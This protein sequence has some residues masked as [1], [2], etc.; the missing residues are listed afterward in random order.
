[1]GWPGASIASATPRVQLGAV[2]D[3]RRAFP[4]EDPHRV[5][6]REQID[7][8][9]EN[10]SKEVWSDIF[11]RGTLRNGWET[12]EGVGPL[13]SVF[14]GSVKVEGMFEQSGQVRVYQIEKASLFVALEAD[15]FI[16]SD[17]VVTA[18]LFIARER[19]AGREYE[20]Q[21]GV[22][23][24]R[25]RDGLLQ[26]EII[27]RGVP[28][29]PIDV[30]WVDDFQ[31]DRWVRLRI[32]RVG[33]SSDPRVTISVNGTPVAERVEMPDLGQSQN[34]I[35]VGL[36]VEGDTARTAR[37]LLDNVEIVRKARR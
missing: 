4:E 22:S 37:V 7:R 35:K 20:I 18:G 6:A 8:I 34:D 29:E 24:Q 23:V 16:S 30:N 28:D 27:R 3:L 12:D 36:F 13:V 5:W 33:D 26:Y 10:A 9:A 31:T 21:G 32:E 17:S 2:D 11:N 1:M 14:E 19:R 25:H 15:V